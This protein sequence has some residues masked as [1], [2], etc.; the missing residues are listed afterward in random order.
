[1]DKIEY[2]LKDI[3][4]G[5]ALKELE[6]FNIDLWL[7]IYKELFESSSIKPKGRTRIATCTYEGVLYRN[8]LDF[9]TAYEKALKK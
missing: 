8:I 5:E 2:Q 3:E 4:S 6:Y 1:M 7:R 9:V